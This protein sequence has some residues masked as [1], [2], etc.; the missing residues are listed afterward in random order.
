MTIYA[1]VQLQLD[2]LLYSNDYT[3]SIQLIIHII[4]HGT[5]GNIKRVNQ[6]RGN[7]TSF[8]SSPVCVCFALNDDFPT[9]KQC[10]FLLLLSNSVAKSGAATRAKAHP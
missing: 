7:T 5:N 4:Q 10:K 1:Y 6:L 2:S 3:D 8:H 9:L